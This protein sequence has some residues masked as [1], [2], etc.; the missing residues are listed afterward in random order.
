MAITHWG[1]T[2]V[3]CLRLVSRIRDVSQEFSGE[4]KRK[5]EREKDGK[6][7]K[8]PVAFFFFQHNTKCCEDHLSGV[9]SLAPLSA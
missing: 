5:R 4:E 3:M 9:V 6:E 7:G 8:I 2:A 1:T